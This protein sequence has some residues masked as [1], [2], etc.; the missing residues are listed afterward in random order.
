MTGILGSKNDKVSPGFND[1]EIPPVNDRNVCISD[2]SQSLR[3]VPKFVIYL[4][5]MLKKC[6]KGGRGGSLLY[7]EV[8][9]DRRPLSRT[10]SQNSNGGIRQKTRRIKPY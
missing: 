5:T 10:F 6:H 2:H 3:F 9:R 7:G 8:P 4:I 1:V